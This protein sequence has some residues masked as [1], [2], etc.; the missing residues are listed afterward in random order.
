[1][2]F[3]GE[4]E[5]EEKKKK[6]KGKSIY[7]KLFI[8]WKILFLIFQSMYMCPIIILF[9]PSFFQKNFTHRFISLLS[10]YRYFF[11]LCKENANVRANVYIQTSAAYWS[12]RSYKTRRSKTQVS[13]NY[14]SISISTVNTCRKITRNYTFDNSQASKKFSFLSFL[15]RQMESSDWI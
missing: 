14:L 6:P 3:H 4:R 9:T 15:G 2:R 12:I 10:R 8:R 1:M 5:R 13:N 7:R 11:H